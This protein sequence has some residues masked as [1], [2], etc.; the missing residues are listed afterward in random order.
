MEGVGKPRCEAFELQRAADGNH[1]SKS[2]GF[3]ING[4]QA[5]PVGGE[6][7]H[8]NFLAARF[9]NRVARSTELSQS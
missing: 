4:L 8:N 6:A 1:G 5:R 7:G 2:R 3:R 9:Q